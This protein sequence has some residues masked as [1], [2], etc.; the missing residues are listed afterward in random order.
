MERRHGELM[1]NS[2]RMHEGPCV[3][4]KKWRKRVRK[5]MGEDKKEQNLLAGMGVLRG[6]NA[7]HNFGN[8]QGAGLR[9]FHSVQDEVAQNC[10]KW[11]PPNRQFQWTMR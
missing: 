1:M 5:E 11:Q 9:L 2:P 6:R 4:S 10:H 3:R 7:G 8:V